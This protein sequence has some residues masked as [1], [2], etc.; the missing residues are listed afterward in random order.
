M[1]CGCSRSGV[2]FYTLP[3][4]SIPSPS[5]APSTSYSAVYARTQ[6]GR[7]PRKRK[8]VSCFLY[9]FWFLFFLPPRAEWFG[10]SLFSGSPAV[11]SSLH[12]PPSHTCTCSAHT[13]PHPP[14]H[15]RLTSLSPS[16]C[17][18]PLPMWPDGAPSSRS[19]CRR[20]N[21]FLNIVVR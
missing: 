14:C 21:S 11:G 4:D 18:W 15:L 7:S 5:V 20:M 3:L 19:L 17:C 1:R 10:P 8:K 2:R 9:H 12:P 6:P 16:T 13:H